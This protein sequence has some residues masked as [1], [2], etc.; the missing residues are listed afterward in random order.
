MLIMLG[1]LQVSS[2]FFSVLG[3][4]SGDEKLTCRFCVCRVVNIMEG[5]L[6]EGK[7]VRGMVFGQ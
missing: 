5:S 2:F 6:S 7:V 3:G 4:G 1:A